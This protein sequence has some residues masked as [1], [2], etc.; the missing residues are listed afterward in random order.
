MVTFGRCGAWYERRKIGR[1]VTLQGTI[2]WFDAEKGYG[3]IAQDDGGEG[4]LVHY[5]GV[6]GTGFRALAEGERVTYELTH[7]RAGGTRATNVTKA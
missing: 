3:L 6:R 5:T 4:L 7:G 2:K 1:V